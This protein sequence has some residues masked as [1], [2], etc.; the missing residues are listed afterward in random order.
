MSTTIPGHDGQPRCRW[1]NAAPEFFDYHDREWGYPV[2]DDRRLFEKLDRHRA[3]S[4]YDLFIKLF[5]EDGFR[6]PDFPG[7]KPDPRLTDPT[8]N[9]AAFLV[10]NGQPDA[11]VEKELL[12]R[13]HPSGGF[14]ATTQRCEPD[15]L[16]TATA[17]FALV[18]MG[19]D[20]DAIRRPCLDYVQSLWRDS[21]GFAGHVADGYEDVE[22]TFYALLAIGCLMEC[23]KVG[24]AS[25][26]STVA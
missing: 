17:L 8:T 19:A 24:Q 20:L 25:S 16:S 5:A 7:E 13:F 18:E 12:D 26:L 10:V 6:R 11:A 21:G 1:C 3:E 9:L 15:L 22:Y 2:G 23:S 14:S 4:A